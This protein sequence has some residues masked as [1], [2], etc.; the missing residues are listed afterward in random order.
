VVLAG[1]TISLATNRW[2]P[3]VV[4][5]SQ[6]PVLGFCA[7]LLFLVG[8]LS[9]FVMGAHGFLSALRWTENTVMAAAFGS[10]SANQSLF[11]QHSLVMASWVLEVLL[12][13]TTFSLQLLCTIAL[14]M[15]GFLERSQMQEARAQLSWLC[16]RDPTYL[17]SEELAGGTLESLSENLSDGTV[18][19]WFWYVLLGP[20]GALGYR[21]ANTLDSRIGYRGGR[22]EWFGKAS[23]RFDDLI[24]L[25]PARLT[26]LLLCV[27]SYRVERCSPSK[28][29]HTALHD[30]RQCSSPNAGWPMGAMAGILGVKLEKRDEYCLGKAIPGVRGPTP[31]DIRRGHGVAQLAG[32]IALVAAVVAC[33]VRE[34]MS[35]V[36]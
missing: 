17:N 27:A 3:Q 11:L 1:T 34:W 7:G 35:A 24:N 15:A 23:A 16:S 32:A 12:F 10:Q 9:L 26:A 29:L 18:A 8:T 13:K 31:S 5:E 21:V 28:G 30:R 25:V 6:R 22:Y 19:P 4:F 2:I 14:Q 20:V 36:N 33:G